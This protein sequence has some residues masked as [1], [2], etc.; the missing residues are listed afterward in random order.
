M[1]SAAAAAGDSVDLPHLAMVCMCRHAP[2]VLGEELD[3]AREP[4]Y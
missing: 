3:A 1:S 4:A 2:A